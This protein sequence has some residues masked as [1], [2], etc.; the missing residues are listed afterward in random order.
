MDYSRQLPPEVWE[1]VLGKLGGRDL[2][3]MS[4]VSSRHYQILDNADLWSGVNLSREK[5]RE[6]GTL[7]VFDTKFRKVS[8]LCLA[9]C[10]KDDFTGLFAYL[11]VT[12]TVHIVHMDLE[13]VDLTQLQPETVGEALARV[14]KINLWAAKLTR[15]QWVSLMTSIAVSDTPVVQQTNLGF[16]DL[17]QLPAETLGMALVRVRK[18]S[19]DWARLT[20]EQWTTFFRQVLST[21]PVILDQLSVRDRDLTAVDADLTGTALANIAN[22]NL[23]SARLTV[24]QVIVGQIMV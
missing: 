18:V 22:L 2:C 7:A 6:A 15:D 20:T 1:M 13:E 11:A 5:L 16:A 9:D 3:N 24:D 12:D 4:L 21:R 8:R 19:L 10:C 17:T 23:R 14:R